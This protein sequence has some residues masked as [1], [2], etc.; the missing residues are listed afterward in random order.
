MLTWRHRL[1][2]ARRIENSLAKSPSRTRAGLFELQRDLT[3]S[4]DV[5]QI[6][7]RLLEQVVARGW[8]TARDELVETLTS[9]LYALSSL[10]DRSAEEV[11]RRFQ[12]PAKPT[13]LL[14]E[15]AQLEHEFGAI[16]VDWKRGCLSITTDAITLEDVE[17]G[18]FAIELQ[19]DR[20]GNA[21]SRCFDIVAINPRPA[22]GNSSVTHPHVRDRTLCAG[23]AGFLIGR[24]LEQGRLVDA[25]QLVISVL[26]NYN[27]DSP[28][29]HLKDWFGEPC[30]D[31][32]R[33]TDEDSFSC[34][35]CSDCLCE[36]CVVSCTACDS[37]RC[38]GCIGS[39]DICDQPCCSSCCQTSAASTQSCCPDCLAKCEQCDAWVATDE[40]NDG[41]RCP[42]CAAQM[43]EED[44]PLE[45]SNDATTTL[46]AATAETAPTD[47]CAT[48]MAQADVVLPCR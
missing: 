10:L 38:T 41:Q 45:E 28:F 29:V 47:L 4:L 32:G 36:S 3:D 8:T 37:S 21:G 20:L 7:C 1:R 31:C 43:E 23:D 46:P 35:S 6:T 25:V 34:G 19:W 22:A 44:E 11:S 15:L 5:I 17:L 30:A 18:E 14:A 27:R 2:I 12:V 26:R 40:I 33:S 42:D 24:A 39:C 9:R 48:S 16:H 13:D